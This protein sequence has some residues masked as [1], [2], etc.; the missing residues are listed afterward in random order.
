MPQQDCLEVPLVSW[1]QTWCQTLHIVLQYLMVANYMWMFCEG[2]H[3]HLALVVVFVKDR[4]V[5]RWFHATGWGLPLILTAVYAG[6][7]G[8]IPDDSQ[9][10]TNLFT[11]T[12]SSYINC[13]YV[14]TGDIKY[15][16]LL[17]RHVLFKKQ[18][19]Y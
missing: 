13:L 8:S 12:G 16:D 4:V 17:K 1:L 2:L 9:R 14:K 6:V 10:Y 18:T 7:R 15:S 19:Y 3:L 5:M 11:G